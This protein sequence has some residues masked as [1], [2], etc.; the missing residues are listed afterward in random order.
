MNHSNLAAQKDDRHKIEG[1]IN[2]L[3]S[4]ILALQN[5]YL[6][7]VSFTV[8]MIKNHRLNV[9]N[10]LR[11]EPNTPRNLF[12]I[13]TRE[14]ELLEAS[15][16]EAGNI[17]SKM[18]EGKEF[19]KAFEQ[20]QRETLKLLTENMP[21]QYI[22]AHIL[23]V[24]NSLADVC[25]KQN[26]TKPASS[27]KELREELR[28]KDFQLRLLQEEIESNLRSI[29]EFQTNI[30]DLSARLMS[31][32]EELCHLTAK[33]SNKHKLNDRSRMRTTISGEGH[34]VN[35][36]KEIA[37]LQNKLFKV[38]KERDIYKSLVKEKQSENQNSFEK[39]SVS[40]E[41]SNKDE[42]IRRLKAVIQY[43]ENKTKKPDLKFQ[44]NFALNIDAPYKLQFV[45][46][47]LRKQHND[48]EKLNT[49]LATDLSQAKT[50]LR[51]L[52]NSKANL[53]KQLKETI[54]LY[55]SKAITDKENIK[56]YSN[57]Y[58]ILKDEY[59][60]TIEYAN[61]IKILLKRNELS[62]SE[63]DETIKHLNLVTNQ[64]KSEVNLLKNPKNSIDEKDEI[65][66]LLESDNKIL[67]DSITELQTQLSDLKNQSFVD[68]QSLKILCLENQITELNSTLTRLSI[69]ADRFN[70][71]S[72]GIVSIRSIDVQ[73]YSKSDSITKNNCQIG[74]LV[75]NF[76]LNFDELCN[77]LNLA[78][79][80][81]KEFEERLK[82]KHKFI[83]LSAKIVTNSRLDSE[84][85]Q[86]SKNI[87]ELV[88]GNKCLVEQV[89]GLELENRSIK[90]LQL[91]NENLSKYM[92]E[93]EIHNEYLVVKAKGLELEIK[94]FRANLQTLKL[95]N[96][97]MN[98][99][100]ILNKSNHTENSIFIL[101]K[102][103]ISEINKCIDAE[104]ILNKVSTTEARVLKTVN[105]LKILIDYYKT[106]TKIL[107]VDNSKYKLTNAEL[108]DNNLEKAT[109]LEQFENERSLRNRQ[110]KDKEQEVKHLKSSIVFYENEVSSLHNKLSTNEKK[111]S[112]FSEMI[113]T[114]ESL[115]SENLNLKGLLL[116]SENSEKQ[117][118]TDQDNKLKQ[119]TSLLE[120]NSKLKLRI[121][122]LSSDNTEKDLKEKLAFITIRYNELEHRFRDRSID[123]NN[124]DVRRIKE[125]HNRQ[126]QILTQDCENYK[127]TIAELTQIKDKK[128]EEL[129]RAIGNLTR[130]I[131]VNKV[132]IT[133]V[134]EVT[135]ELNVIAVY[136]KVK[137]EGQVW[138]LS[139]VAGEADLIWC[140]QNEIEKKGCIDYCKDYELLYEELLS[141]Y[142]NLVKEVTYFEKEC[143]R[144]K[145]LF[146]KVEDELET[147]NYIKG[148]IA[149]K[150]IFQENQTADLPVF[151]SPRI[152]NSRS[153]ASITLEQM[154]NII[155]TPRLLIEDTDIAS[156]KHEFS[157]IVGEE[158]I[159]NASSQGS[160]DSS[161]S[162]PSLSPDLAS[163]LQAKNEELFEKDRLIKDYEAKLFLLPKN[164]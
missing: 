99:E 86:M 36:P 57:K 4:R 44:H 34:G 55:E 47:Q 19:Q 149:L 127:S 96:D 11:H 51:D 160:S 29:K 46:E 48:K 14:G 30:S 61:D 73:S 43:F 65:I 50:K 81:L 151:T 49:E 94:N 79:N 118:K 129:S 63:K 22:K 150:S 5:Q 112:N 154:I 21:K 95:E 128:I 132:R 91:E 42:E 54:L 117:L 146:D 28:K 85:E 25:I 101:L 157:N 139:K 27:T 7:F 122:F 8:E 108:Q 142:E 17:N 100:N 131:A 67:Q 78:N 109:T 144:L 137:H 1:V 113:K 92:K 107:K 103:S 68:T 62:I 115:K 6:N 164:P 161:H 84:N 135:L 159:F 3:Q 148:F 2:T 16:K 66:F 20:A 93:L 35:V 31:K 88:L 133:T 12:D 24:F 152:S 104:T 123:E 37:I 141:K 136:K 121:H 156:L 134:G 52:E 77:K 97:R 130:E 105:A 32:D 26:K 9:D 71:Q 102:S 40:S 162:E 80:K 59:N 143:L 163:L 58:R 18:F 15:L 39:R 64:L 87:K 33:E 69:K 70:V 145:F 74:E 114:N 111:Q 45:M 116:N 110:L 90:V 13:L 82:I 83:E 126:I 147:D 75:Q 38:C 155:K 125:I 60:N 53:E 23:G 10:T 41:G 120:E 72:V 56:E 98:Q 119:I 153:D 140:K 76:Q 89:K 158:S 124:F 106:Q 138:Y